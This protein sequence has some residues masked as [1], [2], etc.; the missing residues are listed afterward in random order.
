MGTTSIINETLINRAK[1]S[2]KNEAV[3]DV[4]KNKR[5]SFDDLLNRASQL[6]YF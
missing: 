3:F 1:I 5:Y 4:K 2:G 6:S